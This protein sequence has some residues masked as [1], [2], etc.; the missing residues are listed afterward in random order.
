M[1]SIIASLSLVL[2]VIT[3][4]CSTQAGNVR[5]RGSLL[6]LDLRTPEQLKAGFPPAYG[7]QAAAVDPGLV[8]GLVQGVLGI[9]GRLKFF[10]VE[11]DFGQHLLSPGYPAPDADMPRIPP[12]GVPVTPQPQP[13]PQ[14]PYV[15][16]PDQ[17]APAPLVPVTPLPP[18]DPQPGTPVLRND[19]DGTTPK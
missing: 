14:P 15:K 10:S 19:D 13:Q 3:T 2:L 8:A 4:G 5:L 7:A 16:P 12:V 18:A 11:A 17:L 1:R 9:K 6:D